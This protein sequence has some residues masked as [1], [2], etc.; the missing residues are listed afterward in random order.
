MK[1]FFTTLVF[2]ISFA[3]VQ[4]LFAQ[5]GTNTQSGTSCTP[6]SNYF[7]SEILPNAGCGV[8]NSLS[9]SPGEYFRMPVL[10]GGCYT[11]STCGS[12]IDTQVMCYE[13]NNTTTPFAYNDDNGPDCSGTTASVNITP[14]FTDYTR[15]DVRQFNCNTGGTASITVKVRQNNNLNITS[16]SAAMCVGETRNLTATPATVTGSLSSIYGN[17]GT[18]SGTGVSGTTFTA[19]TPSGASGTYTITYTFGYCST[20]QNITVYKT[21]T[22]ANAGTDQ[23]ICSSTTTLNANTPT[24]GSGSWSVVSGTQT[25]LNFTNPG[26]TV[27]LTS[28]SLT[29]R[30]TITNG[31]CTSS[32]DEVTIYKDLVDPVINC[33]STITVN[34]LAGQCAKVVGAADGYVV[35]GTDDCTPVNVALTSGLGINGAFPVGTT[36]ETWS[37]TDPSG[38]TSSCSFNVVVNDNQAPSFSSCP[39]DI[40][41]SNDAGTCFGTVSYSAIATDNCPGVSVSVIGGLA[42]GSQFPIGTTQVTLQAQDAVSPTPNT[43]APCTFNVTVTDNENPTITC[44][45]NISVNNESGQCYAPVSW[46]EPSGIDNCPGA[47]TNR[48]GLA[49]GSNFPV[50]TS[51][52]SYTVSDVSSP[53]NTASCSFTVE[54]ID[55]ESPIVSCPASSNVNAAPGQ[56]GLNYSYTIPYS[57]NCSASITQVQGLPS[58]SFFSVGSQTMEFNITDA[59]SNT[60]NCIYTLTV[61]D[62]QDPT[63][64]FCPANAGDTISFATETGL[65]SAIASFN[66]LAADN[67]TGGLVTTHTPSLLGSGSRFELG[68]TDMVYTATDASGNTATCEFVV[69]IKD[70]EF[71]FISCPADQD[72]TFPNCQLTLSDYLALGTIDTSDNCDP[73]LDMAQNPPAGTVVTGQTTVQVS[74]TDN[75]GNTSVCAFTISPLDNVP[76]TI[77]GCPAPG[78]QDSVSVNSSCQF[79]IP[80]YAVL[81]TPADDCNPSPT[82]TQSPPAGTT[83]ATAVN[84]TVSVSDGSN[85]TTCTFEAV[86]KDVTAPT[87]ACPADR[88]ELAGASCSFDLPNYTT[89]PSVIVS[90]NCGGTPVRTQSPAATTTING[91]TTIYLYAED[92]AGNTGSCSFEVTLQD[93]INPVINCPASHD[94]YVNANCLY[95]VQSLAALATTSD[96][97]AGT[98]AVTQ[99]PLPGT[100]VSGT[101][102]LELT[103][104]D[105]AGNTSTCVISLNLIDTIAPNIGC[106]QPQTV[107]VDASCNYTMASFTS[108]ATATDAC[109]A[110]SKTQ[111]PTVGSTFNYNTNP[112]VDVTVYATDADLNTDSCTFQVLLRDVTPPVIT[113]GPN[114]TGVI[115]DQNCEAQLG[116]RTGNYITLTDCGSTPTVTQS[117]S[118]I[119]VIQ[120][121]TTVT[122]TATDAS[123]NASTCTFDV[124]P[125]DGQSPSITLCPQAPVVVNTDANCHYTLGDYTG[126][127]GFVDNCDQSLTITQNP[128]FGTVVTSGSQ[129]VVA[130]KATDDAGNQATCNITITPQDNT[131]PSLT[132]PANQ[133]EDFN[134]NCQFPLGD[135][136]SLASATDNCNPSVSVTQSPVATTIITGTTLITLTA[137]DGANTSTCTFN[138]TPNDNTP[139]TISCPS[140]QDVSFGANCQYNVL[141]YTG[142]ATG[143]TD[144]C[145]SNPGDVVVTQS[146]TT[147]SSI[148]DTITITLTATDAAGNAATCT[149]DVNPS[150]N[151]N[152]NIACPQNQTVNVDGLCQYSI[153]DY[154]GQALTSDA[155]DASVNVTQSPAT[156]SGIPMATVTT[157]TLTGTDDAGNAANCTF[158][159]S[160]VDNLPPTIS[161]PTDTIVA[162]NANCQF[163]MLNETAN[164]ELVLADNCGGT[165]TVTQSPTA[166]STIVGSAVVTL[167]AEDANGN[168]ATC[169]FNY[170]VSDQTNPTILC[171]ANMQ[172]SS[173]QACD[174]VVPDFSTAGSVDDNCDASPVVTQDPAVNQVFV[175]DTLVTLTVTDASGNFATCT[176][177]ISE[178]TNDLPNITCPGDQ[179]VNLDANCQFALADYTTLAVATDNCGTPTVTQTQAAGTIVTGTTTVELV[180][181]DASLNTVSCTFDVIPNDTEAPTVTCLQPAVTVTA[182]GQCTFTVADYT[183]AAYVSATDNC[184]NSFTYTQSPV[185]GSLIGSATT[186]T[187]STTDAVGNVGSCT[188]TVTPEDNS[189]PT[190]FC[191]ADVTVS[192]DANCEFDVPDYTPLVFVSDNCDS[193]PFIVSQSPAIGQTITGESVTTVSFSVTDG[194]SNIGSCSITVTTE[195]NTAPTITCP[196]NEVV[197]ANANCEFTLSDYTSG[198]T[199]VDNCSNLQTLTVVQSPAAGADYSGNVTVTIEAT[200]DAG[201]SNSCTF[202]VTPEDDTNPSLA[203]PPNQTPNFTSNCEFTLVDYTS[204]STVSDFCDNTPFTSQSPGIGTIITGV[205]TVSITAVDANG[206]DSTCTF[207]V[208]PVDIQAPTVTCPSN[209]TVSVDANCEYDI[210]DYTSMVT[211]TDNCTNLVQL[212]QNPSTGTLS[213]SGTT[214]LI[215][216]TATDDNSNVANCTFS[217]TLEDDT[218]P[219]LA[220]CPTNQTVSLNANC[221]FSIV[222]YTVAPLTATDGCVGNVAVTQSPLAGSLIGGTTTVSITATDASGNTDVCSFIVTPEDVTNP[223]IIA[224][225]ANIAVNN[226]ATICGAVVSYPTVTAMDNCAGFIIPQ[227]NGGQVSGTVF[228]VGTTSVEYEAIDGNSNSAFCNFTVTVTDT[229]DPIIVCPADVTE[230]AIAGTCGANVSYHLPTV[231]DNCSGVDSTLLAGFYPGANFPVGTTLVTFE[232]NDVAGNTSTCSFNVYVLDAEAPVITCPADMI[233]SNDAGMCSS[234]VTY[235][236][237]TVT[238]NCT[239]G[240]V[241]S[242]TSGLASGGTFVFGAN[243]VSYQAEDASGNTDDCSF[244]ITVEDNELPVLTCPNDTS[245]SCDATVTYSL[246]MVTD[247]CNNSIVPVQTVPASGYVFPY[248]PTTVTFT[249]DDGNGNIGTCSFEV[250]VI[251][252][253]AP[254]VTCPVDQMESFDAQCQMSAVD[255]TALGSAIDQCDG[256]PVITQSPVAGTTINGSAIITLTATDFAGN[257]GSCTF[258][259]IDD[260]PPVIACPANQQ[261]GSD[262]NCQFT[263]L[264]YTSLVTTSDNC[265][266]SNLSQAPADG[267]V[268]SANTTI[269]ITATDDFGNA[270]NCQFD[271]EL[272]DNI[273]PSITCIGTQVG[274]FDAN[275]EYQLPDYTGQAFA[276]DNC[277]P[278]PIITQF[279]AAGELVQGDT[280]I[281]LTATDSDGNTI[282]CS[283][284][285]IPNDNIAPVITCPTTQQV[286]FDASCSFLMDDYTA[287]GTV[288]DNCSSVFTVTQSPVV[289]SSHSASTIVTLTVEDDAGNSSNCVLVVVPVDQIAPAI[290]CP[291]NQDVAVNSNCE[292]ILTDYSGLATTSDNC[293]NSIVVTQAPSVGSTL[294]NATVVTLTANDGNGN[295]ANCDFTITPDDLTPPNVVCAADIEVD[296][297]V[298]CGFE[299]ADYVGFITATDNC[300]GAITYAQS[301]AAGAV[302]TGATPVTLTATDSNGNSASCSFGITPSDVTPP[303]LVCPSNQIVDFDANCGFE[304]IDYVALTSITDNCQLATIS[305]NLAAGTVISGQTT[306]V[307]TA[308]DNAGNTETCTFNV[309]PSD[310]SNPVVICPADIEVDFDNNCQFVLDD[311]FSLAQVADNCVNTLFTQ[312]PVSGSVITAQTQVEFIVEDDAGNTATCSF[313]VIPSDNTLPSITCPQNVTA[314][315][316]ANCQFEIPDYRSQAMAED[317]CSSSALVYSQFPPLGTVIVS[318]TMVTITAEDQSG[319]QSNC[320][321]TLETEDVI[322]P[323]IDVCP[324]T[325]SVSVNSNCETVIPDFSSQ[326]SA[327]DNCDGI[328]TISQLPAAGT[329]FIGAGSGPITMIATDDAGNETQCQFDA[330]IVDDIDPVVTCPSNQVVELNSS[331]QFVLADY[332]AMSSGSDA[333]GTVTLTQSPVAGTTITTQLNT[334]IIAEDENGNTATCTFFVTPQSMEVSVVGTDATCN[335]GDNGSAVVSVLGGTPPYTEDWGGFDP[336]ALAAGNY[337][338]EVT[339]ANGCSAT[340]NVSIADGPLFELEI[341]PNGTV[342]VCEGESVQLN[343]GTGYAIY[344]WSTGASVASI[345]VSNEAAYW[346]RVADADGCWSTTDTASVVFYQG[347][348]PQITTGSNGL[349]ECSNDSSQT[350]QWYLNGSPIPGA[351]TD[352]HCPTVSGNYV[353]AIVDAN[354]CDVQSGSYE[355]TFNADAPCLVG[356]EEHG[357]TLDV[358]PNPSTGQFTV[359]Y[360]LNQ[361]T[362]VE[363]AVFDLV[364][365]RVSNDVLISSQSGAT[366]IDLSEEAEGVYLLRIK[367]GN[368]KILQQR[369]VLVK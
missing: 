247:N 265:G 358:Y 327:S 290:T 131:A 64:P 270:S 182:S 211:A 3:A 166:G 275:C 104:T 196:S 62:N 28:N 6:R 130:V 347:G 78:E 149:F 292:F 59:S 61:V 73:V 91:T 49:P 339:D 170:T 345:S 114:V 368:D 249:G 252:T 212:A 297:D 210:V 351:V 63:F 322:A 13:G 317:N 227:L 307:I 94:V 226:D 216:I 72:V 132:C 173:N 19:P 40:S 251:D 303:T 141:N 218:N 177:T 119:T 331:C 41:V 295:S 26:S 152:P 60:V 359:K 37:A 125:S 159:V 207:Q 229:E 137:T 364:G 148:G 122:L 367:L 259:V 135:Y 235:S 134:A 321:F 243:T 185:A 179:L 266:A 287:L 50:G 18:F 328:I 190:L 241:P 5:C 320:S 144:N 10:N 47:V 143:I 12:S 124:V 346:V 285:L 171:P 187:I 181:T 150:D 16:S 74:A 318:N 269:T 14:N 116:N 293:S 27:T 68:S 356:I 77:S 65:C 168:T 133:I 84:V 245:I 167:T 288:S 280:I 69:T 329:T 279:P 344:N 89:L 118:A 158:T 340:G 343:A 1:R 178:S 75:S 366:T 319:N 268:V 202:S 237:P 357:L 146:L 215:T 80:D 117:P 334:T 142:M 273:N 316:D 342:Y 21:P 36:T 323:V 161:C 300:N 55:S 310:V 99:N 46:T 369:L 236:L 200:D 98:V 361:H 194:N 42:S 102:N 121:Q 25:G 174:Y 151:T 160:G 312:T 48:T 145:G 106:P 267:T 162:G 228:P 189:I 309:I 31:N 169:T 203:C 22:T 163:E 278:S 35:S 308:V 299:I 302:I 284:G 209:F 326:L 54:V 95:S 136:V 32:F 100:S 337:A 183:G 214:S 294:S 45:G 184:P 240:I 253:V 24:V 276:D 157:V 313:E 155:C 57:D 44:P 66:V 29:L 260:T 97:C 17:R 126:Q 76:P 330:T 197:S 188:M 348:I 362:N 51:T 283:F 7:A 325:F 224:C 20:T 71:P 128:G 274:L 242:L 206:N 43:S 219:G 58:G 23:N 153:N 56:C 129:T 305:Q 272:Y 176:F 332:V 191:P 147:G 238:D 30:W 298:N 230:N 221:Q 67:C 311:Y 110:I 109:S 127:T 9:Y 87:I 120:G 286:Q 96:N 222:D 180:A 363:L 86:P 233:V 204:L 139:P 195:D 255:Y 213:G 193:G 220:N 231:S 354:G 225:P 360:A 258:S 105:V 113:C 70:E 79:L 234:V 306:I 336:L 239:S 232:A 289:G 333:C 223:S 264:D 198:V 250:T 92:A 88:V 11:I 138:V 82:V 93:N 201:N 315:L 85:T 353:V 175:D 186:I 352:S 248:G 165:P 52:V 282:S 199:V 53:Q 123:G 281:T 101:P 335:S 107:D 208:T 217:I 355:I 33:P 140:N 164:H 83:S 90:D 338:V 4:N 254:V 81:L 257:T 341:T 39:G 115:F 263:L 291:S 15:V 205:T 262:I 301:P 172:V 256:A 154:T 296:F 271:L 8:F 350:Y 349:L 277:D 156:S 103:A 314:D 111:F 261:V 108:L 365:T 304:L 112:T 246:P 2:I 38:N 324:P 192:L 244:I 34:A